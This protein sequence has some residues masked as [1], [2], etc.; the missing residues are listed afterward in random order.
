M[1]ITAAFDLT[2]ERTGA[3]VAGVVV[4]LLTDSGSYVGSATTFEDGRAVFIVEPGVYTVRWQKAGYVNDGLPVLLDRDTEIA[5]TMRPGASGLDRIDLGGRQPGPG[6]G[7]DHGDVPAPGPSV[8][9]IDQGPR[10]PAPALPP[11]QYVT[12]AGVPHI[13][14]DFFAPP[15]VGAGGGPWVIGAIVALDVV[16]SLFG[17]GRGES[18]DTKQEKEIKAL[19][20]GLV[21]LGIQIVNTSLASIDR[22]GQGVGVDK[23]TLGKILG[24]LINAVATL[25]GAIHDKLLKYLG[26][27]IK[28]LKKVREQIR[29]IY[30]VWLKPIIAVIDAFRATLKVFEFFGVEWAKKLDD[31]LGTLE[32]KLTAPIL[33]INAKI[34]EL[35][36]WI[37][38]IVTLD[39]AIQRLALLKGLINNA[40]AA[41]NIAWHAVLRRE[42]KNAPRPP[43]RDA[44]K[45]R[46]P[47]TDQANLEQLFYENDGPIAPIVA[48]LKDTLYVAL[49]LKP[50]KVQPDA[51]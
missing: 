41:I 44:Y 7:G 14:P 42:A 33:L 19:Q 38:R 45:A 51:G 16:A 18:T 28:F 11:V 6:G 24:P 3:R 30:D 15:E 10:P 8:I 17:G 48:E 1:S 12:I 50:E 39:G 9:A 21:A 2:D 34:N 13:R 27:I 43:A 37:D 29:H 32:R 47:L 25:F 20:N 49:R 22:D 5:P 36:N 26:P 35:L 46:S 23:G 40:D 4:T 31:K